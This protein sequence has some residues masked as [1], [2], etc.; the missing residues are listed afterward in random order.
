MSEAEPTLGQTIEE[1]T[2]QAVTIARDRYNLALDFSM[3]SMSKLGHLIDEARKGYEAGNISGPALEKAIQIWGSY[4]GE[5]QRRNK[6]GAWKKDTA[7]SGDRRIFLFSQGVKTY[8]FEQVRQKIT[9]ETPVL[10][11]RD[12]IDPVAYAPK[13]KLITPKML[14]ITAGILFVL[15]ILVAGVSYFLDQQSQSAAQTQQRVQYEAAFIPRFGEYLAEYSSIPGDT[16]QITGKVIIVDKNAQT[17]AGLQYQLSDRIRAANPDEANL[18]G[19]LVCGI[20]GDGVDSSVSR[21][22]CTISLVDPAR[23]KMVAQQDFPGQDVRKPA[24]IST[25]HQAV[26]LNHAVDPVHMAQWLEDTIH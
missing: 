25:Y 17:V 8:P 16:P 21:V 13:K 19:Q 24:Q 4:L 5:T 14:F 3:S 6:G 20:T 22:G 12:E 23:G 11:E 7:I 15:M 9:G 1:L 18:V 26:D 10:P 2:R